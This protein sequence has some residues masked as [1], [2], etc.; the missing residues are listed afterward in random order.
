MTG[1]EP[2]MSGDGSDSSTNCA[3]TNAHSLNSCGGVM[4][5]DV[6]DHKLLECM[7]SWIADVREA[8]HT[9]IQT[10][11]VELSIDPDGKLIPPSNKRFSGQTFFDLIL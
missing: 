10:A 1:Y 2:R 4:T 6:L 11:L 3:T 7:L 8:T 5:L 9:F